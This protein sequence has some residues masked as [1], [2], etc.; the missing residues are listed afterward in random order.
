MIA[1]GVNA[2]NLVEEFVQVKHK[3]IRVPSCR[4]LPQHFEL[5][6]TGSWS[7]PNLTGNLLLGFKH[8]TQQLEEKK[9]ILP[10]FYGHFS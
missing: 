9:L 5:L 8:S 10:R 2:Q 7:G 6:P 1:T 3:A 4:V